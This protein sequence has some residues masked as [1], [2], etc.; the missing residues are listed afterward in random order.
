MY[1][2]ATAQY[3]VLLVCDNHIDILASE[4]YL[5]DAPAP[6][7]RVRIN[8]LWDHRHSTAT[9]T[10]FLDDHRAWFY[11]ELPFGCVNM[12]AAPGPGISSYCLSQYLESI[13]ILG[14]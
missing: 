9:L 1:F 14:C 4:L 10:A 11:E 3:G 7:L 8:E 5:V 12:K 2:L 6:M 13:V